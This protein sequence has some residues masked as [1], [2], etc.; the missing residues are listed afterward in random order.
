VRF[1]ARELGVEGSD[2]LFVG[3]TAIAFVKG[4]AAA[5]AKSL[6][7]FARINPALVVKGGLLG[8]KVLSSAEVTTLADLPSRDTLLAQLA[9]AFQ[10][11]IQQF[12]G[13]LQ[14]LPRSFAYGLKALIDKQGGVPAAADESSPAAAADPDGST[15]TA[16]QGG[17]AAADQND[18]TDA[19]DQ[20]SAPT[21]ESVSTEE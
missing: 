2:E 1:A 13:L 15:D 12:A 16:D 17:P 8:T 5:V 18:S 21:A 3:P 19:T 4:D 6:R 11:P 7:D 14:A 10:A 20:D 9:G